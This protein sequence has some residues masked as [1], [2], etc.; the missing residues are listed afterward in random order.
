MRSA[1]FQL[2][3]IKAMTMENIENHMA[4]T[5]KCGGVNFALLKSGAIE[6]NKC[7]TALDDVKWWAGGMGAQLA[8]AIKAEDERDALKAAMPVGELTDAINAYGRACRR[9]GSPAWESEEGQALRAILAAASS[10]PV[11]EPL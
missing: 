2:F 4:Y 11:R 10:Q 7:S 3:T 8:R 5:C 9:D 6:C 1:L